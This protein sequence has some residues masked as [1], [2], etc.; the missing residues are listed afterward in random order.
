MSVKVPLEQPIEWEVLAGQIHDW[1]G[2]MRHLSLHITTTCPIS[3]ASA[4][5]HQT[6]I[7]VG[8]F[9]Y[10]VLGAPSLHF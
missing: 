3:K 7:K 4:C 6:E 5:C 9:S 1:R 8:H 2:P 10:V